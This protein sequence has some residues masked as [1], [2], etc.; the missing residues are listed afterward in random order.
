VKEMDEDLTRKA[1]LV[2]A[3]SQPLV[4][5]KR[6]LNP[7]T[8]YSPHGV[9]IQLFSRAT[10]SETIVP[11]P[12]RGLDHPVIGFFGVIGQ[13]IDVPLLL[14]LARSRPEWTFL[15]VGLVDTDV[16]ELKQLPNVV[17]VGP[18]PYLTLPNWAKAFDVGIIPTLRN[19]QRMNANPL[20]LREYLATGKPVVTVATPATEVF[21]DVVCLANTPPEFLQAIEH[22]LATDSPA[23]QAKRQASVASATWE[24][25]AGE[26]SQIVVKALSMKNDTGRLSPPE[27]L[28]R[29]EPSNL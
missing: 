2:F 13:W 27:L 3:V 25:R 19:P 10:A 15:L 5:N 29:L 4:E 21:Q 6:R 26:I 16:S 12:A 8:F 1:D 20:K 7:N 9:D 22:A 17:F 23:E 18:Q 14:F 28:S 11:E 24:H